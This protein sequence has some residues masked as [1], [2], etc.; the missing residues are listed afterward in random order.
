MKTQVFKD[1]DLWSHKHALDP[2]PHTQRCEARVPHS[3]YLVHLIHEPHNGFQ[4]QNELIL[5]Y[6][7]YVWGWQQIS[8][9]REV[10]SDRQI[11]SNRTID[12]KDIVPVSDWTHSFR[13]ATARLSYSAGNRQSSVAAENKSY[14]LDQFQHVPGSLRSLPFIRHHSTGLRPRY[15]NRR[16]QK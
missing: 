2:P 10:K 15:K 4:T 7:L 14:E 16:V 6:F 12:N 1:V 11:F 3:A 13:E 5:S 8:S 9:F